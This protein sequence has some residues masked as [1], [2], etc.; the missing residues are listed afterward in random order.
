M[1]LLLL[2]VTAAKTSFAV[3]VCRLF[4]LAKSFAQAVT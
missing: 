3:I 1:V 4:S 2:T